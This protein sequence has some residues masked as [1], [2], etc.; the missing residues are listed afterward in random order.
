[1]TTPEGECP[2]HQV[3]VHLYFQKMPFHFQNCPFIFQ[4]CPIIFSNCPF[5]FQR[6][7]FVFQKFPLV[8]QKILVILITSKPLYGVIFY[9]LYSNSSLHDSLENAASEHLEWLKFKNFSGGSS[10]KHPLDGERLLQLP[11]PQLY[12]TLPTATRK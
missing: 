7:H 11:D 5:V 2:C 3:N 12:R 9:V 8:C 1:M 10:P 4:K 6:C